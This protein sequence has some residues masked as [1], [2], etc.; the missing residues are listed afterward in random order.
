[1]KR[2]YLTSALIAL[3]LFTTVTLFGQDPSPVKK[4]KVITHYELVFGAGA[5]MNNGY[6]SQYMTPKYGYSYGFGVG[7]SFSK[8]FELNA[9]GLWELKGSK[10]KVNSNGYSSDT[11]PIDE[12]YYLDTDFKYFT[13]SLLPTFKLLRNKNLSI[14]AGGYY[15]WLRKASVNSTHV[16]NI[17]GTSSS[18]TI[19]DMGNFQKQYDAGFIL[20]AGYS[21]P[22]SEKSACQLQLTYNSGLVDITD[23]W[24]GSQRNKSLMLMVSFNLESSFLK[25]R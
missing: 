4:G 25:R 18:Y 17:A 9:R 11:G 1:M 22:I 2:P 3:S 14:G 13:A 21:I 10:V 23:V 19:T 16:D 12:T 20:F 5:L 8:S 15:S 24:N 6:Y 7:H